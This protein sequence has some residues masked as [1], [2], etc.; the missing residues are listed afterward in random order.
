MNYLITSTLCTRWVLFVRAFVRD[1]S[2]HYLWGLIL[3]WN[4]VEKGCPRP[5]ISPASFLFCL[6]SFEGSFLYCRNV[7]CIIVARTTSLG[8]KPQ[9]LFVVIRSYSSFYS[10][11]WNCVFRFCFLLSC[12]CFLVWEVWRVMKD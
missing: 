11:M 10:A 4:P 8:L 9:D 3:A 2:K 7:L 6:S 12:F 5:Y 1:N